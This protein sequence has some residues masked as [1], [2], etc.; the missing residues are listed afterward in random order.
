MQ[1][2]FETISVTVIN[3]FNLKFV[4]WRKGIITPLIVVVTEFKDILSLPLVR[5]VYMHMCK[6][7]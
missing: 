5:H 1:N 3:F 2:L 6:R 4:F 7:Q